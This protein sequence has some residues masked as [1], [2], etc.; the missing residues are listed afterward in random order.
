MLCSQCGAQVGVTDE[1]CARCGTA[2]RGD[3]PPRAEAPAED[4][5]LVAAAIG[6]NTEYYT[7]RFEAFAGGDAISWNW[8]SLFVPFAWFLYRKMWVHALVYFFGVPFI[9]G[10]LLALL[11][12]A[13]GGMGLMLGLGLWAAFR[14]AVLPMFANALYYGVVKSRVATA[15]RRTGRARQ[16]KY[17]DREGGTSNVAL[18]VVIVLLV[19]GFGVG[20]LGAIAIP[21]YQD[22]TV[23]SQVGEGTTLAEGV[24]LAV[25]ETFIDTGN[26]PSSLEEAGLP[27]DRI[28]GAYVDSVDING[29]RIDI[30]YGHGSV[31]LAGRVL[32]MTPY[33]V[34]SDG[35]TFIDWRCGQGPVPEGAI[36][37]LAEYKPGDLAVDWPVWVPRNC[38]LGGGLAE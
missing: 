6:R 32:S 18:I 26:V 28:E 30:R 33:E 21:A 25:A 2:L 37:A 34:R 3:A 36:R 23:R 27:P 17:V 11:A 14:L 24:K 19:P 35:E 9:G 29:G 5:E 7:P 4:S 20:L 16:L 12:G 10:V 22:Y 8:P 1:Y 31:K 38:R 15:K 13:L